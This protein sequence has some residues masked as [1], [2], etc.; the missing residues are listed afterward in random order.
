MREFSRVGAELSAVPAPTFQQRI[1]QA[2]ADGHAC[3]DV[4]IEE[5]LIYQFEEAQKPL[6]AALEAAR[7]E[8]TTL[9]GLVAC[10]GAAPEETWSIDTSKVLAQLDAVLPPPEK[11]G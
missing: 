8:L 3:P 11:Q 9:H 4:S 1:W 6:L 10:D 2:I 7:H 5:C